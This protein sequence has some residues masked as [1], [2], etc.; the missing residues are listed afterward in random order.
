MGQRR[1]RGGGG[2]QRLRCGAVLACNAALNPDACV[3]LPRA[4]PIFAMLITQTSAF[5]TNL[6]ARYV[7]T[8]LQA[9]CMSIAA[10]PAQCMAPA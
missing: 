9:W 10:L 3:V 5:E 8:C 6:S 7:V 1:P 2:G 4:G